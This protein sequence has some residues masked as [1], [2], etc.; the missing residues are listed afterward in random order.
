M[1]R[2]LLTLATI[3]LIAGCTGEPGP[4][5]PGGE[6]GPT[7]PQGPEGTEGNDGTDGATGPQGPEG[8]PGSDGSDGSDGADGPPGPQGGTTPDRLSVFERLFRDRPRG[9]PETAPAIPPELATLTTP[10]P[11]FAGRAVSPEDRPGPLRRPRGPL[12][13]IQGCHSLRWAAIFVGAAPGVRR[14]LAA[15]SGIYA[16]AETWT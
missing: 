1:N 5:G 2:S 13:A 4:T 7:G 11:M 6:P 16:E 12:G 9:T 8:P 10:L 14:N 15:T 3:F